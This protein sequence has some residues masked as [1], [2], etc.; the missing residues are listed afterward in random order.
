M[1]TGVAATLTIPPHIGGCLKPAV[2]H[3]QAGRVAQS[4]ECVA[5]AAVA[6]IQQHQQAFL[7]DAAHARVLCDLYAELFA[8]AGLKPAASPHSAT[9]PSGA[10][11]LRVLYLVSSLV[12]GQAASANIARFCR[13]HDPSR[14][15]AHVLC[16]EEFTRRT[17]TLNFLEYPDSPSSRVGDKTI[18]TLPLGSLTLLEPAGDLLAGARAAIAA[19]RALAPDV[20]VFVAS[21]A[22]PVQAACAFARI[23][24]RQVNMNIGVPLPLSGIDEIVYNSPRRWA[25]DRAFLTARGIASRSVETSGGD[26]SAGVHARAESR[27]DLGL[28]SD[29]LALVSAGNRLPQRLLAG[30]FVR[31]LDAFLSSHPHAWWVGVGPGDF[32]PIRAALGPGLARV[33]TPGPRADIRPIVKAC[34][35][36]LNEYPEG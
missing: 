27:V 7:A 33:I 23:A 10:R 19:S 15:V 36:Y 2:D 24:P 34:D 3:A 8:L 12:D 25:Q 35:I 26:A 16:V 6:D 13:L 5:A 21:P 20:A 30:S 18:A 17:P 29:A 22:C 32:A 31:D 9:P 28:P 1:F 4:I 11:P 14:F